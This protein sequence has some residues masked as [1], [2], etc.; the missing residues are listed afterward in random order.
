MN[1]VYAMAWKVHCCISHSRQHAKTCDF[2]FDFDLDKRMHVQT[3][4]KI[5]TQENTTNENN[6]INEIPFIA[7]WMSV[8]DVNIVDTP[9]SKMTL[10]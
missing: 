9:K 6:T 8:V 3:T 10:I 2:D 7:M 4:H 5:T 1:A